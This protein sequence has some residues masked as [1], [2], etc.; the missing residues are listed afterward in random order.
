MGNRNRQLKTYAELM[1]IE[2]TEGKRTIADVRYELESRSATWFH[3]DNKDEE[4][5]KAFN[6]FEQ[7]VEMISD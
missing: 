1:A 4:F 5:L 7:S 2:F 3:P 6:H